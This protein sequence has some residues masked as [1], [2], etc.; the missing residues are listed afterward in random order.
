VRALKH[1]RDVVA[2]KR[3]DGIALTEVMRRADYSLEDAQRSL[4]GCDERV[5]ETVFAEVRYQPYVEREL[6]EMK[7]QRELE[8]K[9]IPRS[10][11]WNA[12]HTLRTE[13]R[14]A[15]TKFQ[16][17]TFGQASRLEGVTPADLTLMRVLM[18]QA[19]SDC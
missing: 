4:A 15:L 3:I 12:C 14:Q 6:R 11:D 18:A 10:M 13:A 5:I 16:P 19:R 8:D 1:A 9:L 2:E 17:D 7:R